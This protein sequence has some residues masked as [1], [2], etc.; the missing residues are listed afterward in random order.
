MKKVIIYLIYFVLVFNPTFLYAKSISIKDKTKFYQIIDCANL[1]N[2]F[3]KFSECVDKQSLTSRYLG[4]LKNKHK[5]EIF[6]ILAVVNIINE[7]VNEE[8]V[9]DQ[10]A[11]KNWNSFLNSN[12]KKKSSKK[13][14]EKILDDSNCK[15]LKDYDEFIDCFNNEFRNYEVYQNANIKTKERMEHIVFNSLTLT[16]SDGLVRTLKKENLS[17]EY[18]DK[19]Y[20]NE[21][22]YDFFFT[23]MNALGTDYFKKVKDKSDINWKKVITFIIIA[24]LIAYMAKSLLKKGS[25]GSSQSSAS[26]G[27]TST[28]GVTNPV[29]SA[30]G[31]YNQIPVKYATSYKITYY[32]PYIDLTQ[33]TWFKYAMKSR[34]GF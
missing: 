16:K 13:K 25:S 18:Y 12:Y 11:F 2:N 20:S 21:D 4:K 31:Y 26:S 5:R 34:F 6:D 33:K 17:G 30:T 15:N 23:L 22:G 19:S 7:S 9:D 3:N 1:V 14:L 10:K 8:F 27:S 32:K 28:A 24:I 29:N